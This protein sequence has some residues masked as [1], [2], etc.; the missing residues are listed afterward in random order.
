MP[1]M[2]TIT[3]ELTDDQYSALQDDAE[4]SD[5]Y[6]EAMLTQEIQDHLESVLTWTDL[7]TNDIKI[8]SRTT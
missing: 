8:D 1:K 4:K 5:S 3:V 2:I 6:A 7:D